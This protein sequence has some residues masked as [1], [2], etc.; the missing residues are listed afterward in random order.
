MDALKVVSAVTRLD[1]GI[2]P[3]CHSVLS[4]DSLD[5]STGE[6]ERNGMPKTNRCVLDK[7]VV[8]CKKCGYKSNAISIGLKIIPVDRIVD[9]DPDWDKKYLE[10]NTL[11]F[12]EKGKNPFYKKEKE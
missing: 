4:Y 2:C 5:V 7:Y 9:F 10:E 6:L 12:G 3:H 1:N 8:Y 11:V